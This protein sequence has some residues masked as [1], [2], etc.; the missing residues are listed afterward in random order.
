MF[1]KS[2]M[3]GQRL[4]IGGQLPPLSYATEYYPINILHTTLLIYQSIIQQF[5]SDECFYTAKTKHYIVY[6]YAI[7]NNKKK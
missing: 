5:T 3:G 4:H 2:H 7:K 1:W 6:D